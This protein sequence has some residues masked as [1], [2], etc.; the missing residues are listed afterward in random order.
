MRWQSIISSV[1][2]NKPPWKTQ[3]PTIYT[4]SA[5]KRLVAAKRK[6]RATWQRIHTTDS[7]RLYNQ[8]S[9]NLKS[10]LRDMRNA[11]F[12][13]YVSTLK[14]D[15]NSIWKPIKNRKKNHT[16][17]PPIRKRSTPP[18]PWA[19]TDKQKADLFA[20]HL[21]AVFTPHRTRIGS[22]HSS[23]N[24]YRQYSLLTEHLSTV[25][26]P[27]RTPIGSIHSSQQRPGSGHRKGPSNTHTTTGNPS[28]FHTTGNYK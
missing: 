1:Y 11:S 15:D 23:Q 18:G 8:A 22:I 6:A 3:R 14:R 5:I 21:S 25:F 24:T 19:K 7:R 13:T 4:P 12:T 20:E 28:G 26:T 16:S 2:C 27:H 17:I 9:S 10:A